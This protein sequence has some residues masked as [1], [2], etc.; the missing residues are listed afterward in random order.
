MKRTIDVHQFRDAFR[1]Y[2]RDGEFSY[3]G[4]GAL[5]EYFED[6][7]DSIGEEI[8]LDVVAICCDFSEHD[9]AIDAISDLG[10]DYEPEGD[11]DE[12]REEGALDWLRDQTSVIEFDG[13]IIIQGF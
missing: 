12:E 13:G 10:Y 3:N 1:D 11:T 5:F 9:S 4:L 2:G 8:E 7:G 6:L